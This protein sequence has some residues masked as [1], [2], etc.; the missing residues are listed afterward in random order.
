MW[1]GAE[2]AEG[3]INIT[4]LVVHFAE[5]PSC[6]GMACDM[7]DTGRS[8]S[9]ELDTCCSQ[10][11]RA[12]IAGSFAGALRGCA[13]GRAAGPRAVHFSFCSDLTN[14]PPWRLCCITSSP[15]QSPDTWLRNRNFSV[16]FFHSKI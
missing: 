12:R 14:L 13:G 7:I 1:R 5:G 6:L 16:G 8:P 9:G 15:V 3:I 4:E 10:W 11:R 2:R